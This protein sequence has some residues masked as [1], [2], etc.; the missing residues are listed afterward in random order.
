[1]TMTQR[2]RSQREAQA[3]QILLR[4]GK[5]SCSD[6]IYILGRQNGRP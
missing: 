1:M 5:H 4:G 6:L 2:L 3:L